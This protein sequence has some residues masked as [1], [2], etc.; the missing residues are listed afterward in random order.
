MMCPYMRDF[1][2][3]VICFTAQRLMK[4]DN[5]QVNSGH[6]SVPDNLLQGGGGNKHSDRADVVEGV[7]GMM[8]S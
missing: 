3:H 5:L 7:D 4:S 8:C 1:S 2:W 6:S